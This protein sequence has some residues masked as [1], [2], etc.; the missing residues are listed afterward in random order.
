MIGVPKPEPREKVRKRWPKDRKPIARAKKGI[1]HTARRKPATV[2]KAEKRR[3]REWLRTYGS[4]DRVLWVAQQPSIASGALGCENV[5]V[6]T[7][8]MG[9][10]A[11]ACWIVPLTPAEHRELHRIG[12]RSF[13]Q[14]YQ[15]D[16]DFEAR[17]TEAAWQ[18]HLQSQ[19]HQP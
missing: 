8:G 1:A 13:E 14:K 18:R 10:K 16:L 17:A 11:D 2:K 19:G 3:R 4:E 15:V 12:I 9:R 5:H 7:G 6:R